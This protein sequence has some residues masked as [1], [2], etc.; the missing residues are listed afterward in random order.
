MKKILCML[1]ALCMVFSLVACAEE[2]P[3]QETPDN[4]TE[5]VAEAPENNQEAESAPV[6]YEG[7]SVEIYYNTDATW[8]D[9]VDN[10]AKAAVAEAFPGLEV[11][12]TPLQD[13]P[14]ETLAA[15]GELPD[16]FF[17]TVSSALMESGCV[18]DLR[19]YM[20]DWLNENFTNPN[21]YNDSKEHVWAVGSG[22]DTF[23]TSVYYYNKDVFA[24]LGLSAPQTF[25]EFKNV[26]QTLVDAGWEIPVSHSYWSASLF[27]LEQ[28]IVSY[29]PQA[30][31]DLM[32]NKTDFNDPRIRAAVANV[33]EIM[34]MGALGK[35][36]AE[37]DLTAS[38]SEFVEG[39]AAIL[40]TMCWNSGAVAGQ[41]DFDV[42]VFYFPTANAE[43]ANGTAYTCWGSF[44]NGWSV[45]AATEDP[46]LTVEVLK[47][48]VDAE[49]KRNFDNGL[50]TNYIV[51][52]DVQFANDLDAERY[53]LFKKVEN[54]GTAFYPNAL[55]SDA[56][57]GYY[58]AL[59]LW[60]ADDSTM[61]AD[62][63]CDAM[64][65]VWENNRFFELF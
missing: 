21:F 44:L 12:F 15:V 54:W 22:T 51:E 31:A 33:Q 63:F 53:E 41:T 61:D 37:K 26:C 23:Y 7:K 62:G 32:A 8:T 35:G 36:V 20:S 38:I 11:V 4:G 1:M 27:W 57:G 39:D 10:Y 60:L 50:I 17:G 48:L 3:V 34:D 2:K 64:Q 42:G 59:T 6:S 56:L 47:V 9:I 58:D 55:D 49:A 45:N 5:P 19:P 65:T 24:D 25:E 30:Y 18:L 14:Y 16:I 29:D 43:V 13:V 46:E 28:A 52:G 40:A